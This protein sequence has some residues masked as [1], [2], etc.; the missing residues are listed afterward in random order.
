MTPPSIGS[1]GNQTAGLAALAGGVTSAAG[2]FV[3][4]LEFARALVANSAV[5][6]AA[7]VAGDGKFED[8]AITCAFGYFPVISGPKL[9][10][11]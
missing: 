4:T 10:M 5:G 7:A 3:N 9:D 11:K 1:G 8:G 6:G 2:T